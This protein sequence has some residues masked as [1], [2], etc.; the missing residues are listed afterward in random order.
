MTARIWHCTFR[1]FAAALCAS[2]IKFA[3]CA[4]QRTWWPLCQAL[5]FKRNKGSSKYSST[6]L[7]YFFAKIS[8]YSF[9]NRL[10]A[11]SETADSAAA[12]YKTC[13]HLS[14]QMH[15]QQWRRVIMAGGLQIK[16]WLIF[17]NFLK[18][19]LNFTKKI[20]NFVQILNKFFIKSLLWIIFC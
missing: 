11:E 12:N 19:F 13:G 17:S 2:R 6:A 9:S 7:S 15:S 5:L 1:S 14:A 18:F 8:F 16:I 20:L 4:D 3:T 10:Y